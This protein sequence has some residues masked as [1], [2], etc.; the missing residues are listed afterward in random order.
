MAE[1]KLDSL[2]KILMSG[3]MT[4]ACGGFASLVSQL[5]DIDKRV[6]AVENNAF[7][8]R[9]GDSLKETISTLA[10]EVAKLP[11]NEPPPWLVA[12]MKDLKS[13]IGALRQEVQEM[14]YERSPRPVR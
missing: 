3:A 8:V 6:V 10:L 11:R 7:K 2:L 4:L 14:R 12:Q 9:D 1:G 13:D 5:H